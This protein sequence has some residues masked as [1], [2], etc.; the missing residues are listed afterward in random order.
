M[1]CKKQYDQITNYDLGVLSAFGPLALD[2]YL[3]GLPVLQR[4]LPTT[5][6]MTQLS[7]TAAMFGLAIGQVVV[8]PLSD[9]LGRKMPLIY[10]IAALRFL[11]LV[12][13]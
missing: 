1:I 13:R 8:G 11:R 6:T 12:L 5:A 4:E 10:G 7:I 2:L 9:R 3:P